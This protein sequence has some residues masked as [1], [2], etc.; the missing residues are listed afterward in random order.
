[1]L[2]FSENM[3]VNV[4]KFLKPKDI[5]VCIDV[6]KKFKTSFTN[7]LIW[8]NICNQMDA[9]ISI[10]DKH[11]EGIELYRHLMLVK[12]INA[13][14]NKFKWNKRIDEVLNTSMIYHGHNNLGEIPKEL[15]HLNKLKL[16]E[17]VGNKI[18]TIPTHISKLVNLEMLFL[19]IGMINLIPNEMCQLTK[20]R[21]LTLFNNRI[22]EFP[23]DIS[24]LVNLET[25]NLLDNQISEIPKT[26]IITLP[27]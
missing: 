15:T 24:K 7:P 1:M 6:C 9:L 20:L 5:I 2:R 21:K 13:L 23:S 11:L 8:N 14:N 4:S 12:D 17:L 22:T 3:F 10:K 19:G 25:L 26:L 16:L 18:T 27:T